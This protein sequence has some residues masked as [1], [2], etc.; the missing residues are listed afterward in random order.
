M[1]MRTVLDPLF[2]PLS[3]RASDRNGRAAV[4]A[5]SLGV[6]LCAISTEMG[7]IRETNDAIRWHFDWELLE[8]GRRKLAAACTLVALL[9]YPLHVSSQ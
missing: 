2:F 1:E 6:A 3:A 8:L 7:L 9:G 4:P 5:V